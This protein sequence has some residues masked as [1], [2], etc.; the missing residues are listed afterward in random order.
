MLA[1]Q[2]EIG[3]TTIALDKGM[4]AKIWDIE[5][6]GPQTGDVMIEY[7]IDDDQPAPDWR[8]LK[9]IRHPV[10]NT[11]ERLLLRSRPITVDAKN[12]TTSLRFSFEDA[13]HDAGEFLYLTVTIEFDDMH[14]QD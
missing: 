6:E 1:R 4:V 12:D 3:V 9:R 2:L 7:A 10:A 14:T 8:E 5:I 11:P 13:S